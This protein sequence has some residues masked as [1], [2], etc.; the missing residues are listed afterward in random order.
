[1][2]RSVAL[3]L[4]TLP[5][6][7]ADLAFEH[8]ELPNGVR[9]I[10]QVDRRA[11][12]VYLDLRWRVGSK[13][14]PPGRTGLAH[15]FEHLLFQGA[16]PADGFNV[17]A[18]R[19]G[20]T[21]VNASTELDFTEF[22]ETVPAG[23]LE[24]MLWMES[25]RFAGLPKDLT[26]SALD[27]QREVVRN[28]RRGN[29]E[30]A[31]YGRIEPL[32][33]ANAFPPGHP[34]AHDAGGLDEDIRAATVADALAFYTTYYTADR[35][36]I[37]V[38]GDFDPAQV[39]TWI[40]KY[41]G[42][43]APAGGVPESARSVPPL[44]APKLVELRDR[45]QKERIFFVRPAPPASDPDDAALEFVRFIMTDNWNRLN[46]SVHEHQWKD[47]DITRYAYQDAS[48]FSIMI[49]PA[50]EATFE[51][52]EKELAAA[53][54]ELAREGPTAEEMTRARNNLEHSGISDMES[55]AGAAG[56]LLYVQQL[57]GTV[58]RWKAW[59]ERYSHVTVDD[60]KGAVA[61]WLLTPNRLAVHVRPEVERHT[62]PE[63]DRAKAPPFQPEKQFRYPEVRS[64]RL[65]N[66]LEVYVV[67]RHS[68]PLV[69]VQLRF[70]IGPA[71]DPQGKEGLAVLTGATADRGTSSGSGDD[72]RNEASHLGT[73]I[74]GG[75]NLSTQSIGF[76]VVRKNLDPAVSLLADI[77]LHASYPEV[78]V[79]KVRDTFLEE[80]QTSG[81]DI[82]DVGEQM[83]RA[84]F[85]DGHPFGNPGKGTLASLRRL[86]PRDVADFHRRYWKPGA[87]G[88]FFAGDV[89]L[90]DAVEIVRKSLGEWSGAAEPSPAV[91]PAKPLPGRLFLVDKKGA[92]QTMVVQVLPGVP[93]NSP[94]YPAL[95]IANRVRGAMAGS[96]LSQNIRQ[97]KGM[98]YTASSL[99]LRFPGLGLWVAASPVQADKTGEAV[100]EF[101]KELRDIAG[102]RPITAEEL[103]VAKDG[104]IR[105]EIAMADSVGTVVDAMATIWGDGL[106]V[107][108][109]AALSRRIASL[110]L[111]EVNAVARKY[112]RPEQAF[113]LLSGDRD[114]IERQIRGLGLGDPAILQ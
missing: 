62:T 40:A 20:A 10:L 79:N 7:H 5:A 41:F 73:Q 94:D 30:N 13:N 53:L 25:N 14:E 100:Q 42:W 11:P 96:R 39:R 3:A 43:M 9:V 23:R 106:P 4:L 89:T 32:I 2:L 18:E 50:P 108:D 46:D 17:R 111:A 93:R 55:L 107:V 82:N 15:L 60:V 103:A 47:T 105:E 54:A 75:S 68:L 28:E 44:P 71:N 12:V 56:A 91:P 6:L 83:L 22:H 64:G 95:V 52:A 109:L 51:S 104:L 29:V 1:M 31:S 38:A 35:L 77:V 69:A 97:D 86:T 102:D 112:A 98:A 114:I 65:A 85:G 45:V 76:E 33:L 70:R 110:T 19:L 21:G 57:Y 99:L 49:E 101:R 26:Q 87:A 88:L 27:H 78:G 84:A 36:S 24:R 8:Y 16:D 113:F 90:E 37:A 67:E 63:P 66:G 48:L 61:R 59:S 80:M 92:T 34:Y 58:D 74:H 81:A 72:I